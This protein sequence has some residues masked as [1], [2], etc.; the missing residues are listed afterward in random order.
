MKIENAKN[1]TKIEK[2]RI[3]KAT[4]LESLEIQTKRSKETT[5]GMKQNKK[6]A[7]KEK[8]IIYSSSELLA[9]NLK[10]D[11][12]AKKEE[13]VNKVKIDDTQKEEETTL[14]MTTNEEELVEINNESINVDKIKDEIVEKCQ[15]KVDTATKKEASENEMNTESYKKDTETIDKITKDTNELITL[16]QESNSKTDD[17]T[18]NGENII[19]NEKETISKECPKDQILAEVTNN[20]KE[21]LDLHGNE[22]IQCEIKAGMEENK[23][24]IAENKPGIAENGK[25]SES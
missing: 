18:K 23:P 25:I 7:N 10:N 19:G 5:A 12:P 11:I 14:K 24:G 20:M 4:N 2:V 6:G 8:K 16:D 22:E 1:V 9:E 15:M 13:S 17:Q 3:E 21:K